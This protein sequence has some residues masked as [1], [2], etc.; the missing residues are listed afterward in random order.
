VVEWA[1]G[2]QLVLAIVFTPGGE[3]LQDVPE[4]TCGPSEVLVGVE[5]C[6]I[7]GTDLHASTSDFQDGIVMGHEFS[8]AIVEVGSE[9]VGW[10]I[11]DTVAVNPN[12]VVCGRCQSCHAGFSNL[13]VE[14]ERWNV[15][16]HLPG[17]LAPLVALDPRRLHRL[18]ANVSTLQGAW[19]EPLAVAV[20]TVDRSEAREDAKAVVFGAGPIGL[21][22]AAVLRARGIEDLTVVEPAPTRREAALRMG[23]SAVIDPTNTDP[24]SLFA[25]APSLAFECTGVG[26]VIETALNVLRPTGR[27]VV[28]GYS[29]IPPTYRSEP[30]LF[31]ELD[32][33]ASF[34]YR[35][36]EF[37]EALRLLESGAVDVAALTSGI[38]PIIDAAKAF[39]QMRSSSNAIK[40]LIGH[41]ALTA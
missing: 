32:I 40:F 2:Q 3:R 19:A 27:L 20:R 33:R 31:K 16:Q 41:G 30:L 38:V 12:G 1:K 5:C 10:D 26:D 9:V 15:G 14:R 8:G 4:P 25:E 22:V 24:S 36:T 29:R 21:L 23:A 17:G 13:C 35:T 18:P 7:C 39:E 28:T 34:I 6:G 37:P 11:G